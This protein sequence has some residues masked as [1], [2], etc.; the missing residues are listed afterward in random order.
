MDNYCKY[1]GLSTFLKL[2][3]VIYL[4][5]LKVCRRNMYKKLQREIA[6]RVELIAHDGAMSARG[7]SGMNTVTLILT[8]CS[9][10]FW[11]ITKRGYEKQCQNLHVCYISTYGQGFVKKHPVTDVYSSENM[12][13]YRKCGIVQSTKCLCTQLTHM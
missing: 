1:L 6:M 13:E 12:N 4:G 8:S 11:I 3:N 7:W 9:A 5:T 2:Y 10:E